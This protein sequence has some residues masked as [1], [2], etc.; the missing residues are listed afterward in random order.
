MK[1]KKKNFPSVTQERKEN[2]LRRYGGSYDAA[3]PTSPLTK[4]NVVPDNQMNNNASTFILA[5]YIRGGGGL[6]TN[7]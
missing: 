3:V 2:N 6:V 5:I 4:I 1:K 7:L